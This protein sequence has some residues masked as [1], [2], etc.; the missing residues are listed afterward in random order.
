MDEQQTREALE[1]TL[2]NIESLKLR[3]EVIRAVVDSQA[4]DDGLWFISETITE[5]YLQ[6]Q[7]RWLHEVIEAN[8]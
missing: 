8:G 5:S 7:L 2:A 1:D 6:S 4:E 3:M